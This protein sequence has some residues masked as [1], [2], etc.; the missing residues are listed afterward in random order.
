LF[1]FVEKGFKSVTLFSFIKS[2][3]SIV[4]VALEYVSLKQ[5]GTYWKGTCPFH[6]ETDASF[7]VSPDRGIFYCFGC[8]S[9]GD[10]IA[11]IAKKEQ[12]S[13]IEAALH[14]VERYKL[15]VPEELKGA[16]VQ[17]SDQINEKQHFHMICSQVAV[18]ACNRLLASRDAL[19]YVT[20]RGIDRRMID[21]FLL[22]YLP[23]GT[24]NINEFIKDM[25]RK[26]I[27]LKDLIGA[28]I[29]IQNGSSVY[30]PFEDRILFPINDALGRGIGFGG[31]VF[32]SKDERAKYYNSKD[33]DFFQ[34]GHVLFGLD[35]AKKSMREAGYAFLVEG[36]TD[37]VA[38]VKAGYT[39][40]VATL[41]TACTKDHL[42]LISRYIN[43]VYVVYDGDSAGQKAVLRFVELC[44]GQNLDVKIMTLPTGEDPA[45]FL[46]KDGDLGKLQG[47]ARDIFSFFVDIQGRSFVSKSLGE[48][49]AVSK[50]IID[51]I[52]S[53]SESI[54][55]DLLLQ[56]ASAVL[57]VPLDSLKTA[58]HETDSQ[59]TREPDSSNQ[60]GVTGESEETMGSLEK[61][62]VCAILSNS[63]MSVDREL[64]PF[65][66]PRARF[67]LEKCETLEHY[68]KNDE[69]FAT[70]YN[71]LD[72]N[73]QREL[74]RVGLAI[75]GDVTK[76]E[77]NH[78][79][80]LFSKQMW[81]K[82]VQDVKQ[83]MLEAQRGGDLELFRKLGENFV[84]LKGEMKG[85]GLI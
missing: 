49:L 27:L 40:T 85:R 31:R 66:S 39:Q 3:L 84:K 58:L 1:Y 53:V 55:Q 12:L 9:G 74:S 23:G 20:K 68:C 78:Y 37:C 76:E 77:F 83:R 30:S 4:D 15:D 11:F 43:T 75:S 59:E 32:H 28:G 41:G 54:K 13:Q 6:N 73:A 22:G 19:S 82:R 60:Q 56:Q 18:W 25:S 14:L 64:L 63:D 36:Y 48:K 57:Q 8:H 72:E 29:V 16:G 51:I 47:K 61:K 70:L 62:I 38:M 10:L 65:F 79:I 80:Y 24:R 71:S 5:A 2:R 26:N 35:R 33:S 44:L 7:T 69:R 67:F 21:Y 46:E 52:A 42:S 34:K 17:S 50:K 81:K 45:S